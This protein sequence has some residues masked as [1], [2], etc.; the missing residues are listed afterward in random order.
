MPSKLAGFRPNGGIIK[1]TNT[2][3]GFK[4]RY[5]IWNTGTK[6]TIFFLNGRTEYIEKYSETISKF[7]CRNY[8]VVSLDWRSQGLSQRYFGRRDIGHINDFKEYQVDLKAI[9]A[10]KEVKKLPKPFI[11]VSHSMGGLIGLRTLISKNHGFCGAIFSAP[12]WGVKI[13]ENAVLN[14]IKGLAPVIKNPGIAKIKLYPGGKKPY[15]LQTSAKENSLTSDETQFKR[16]QKIMKVEPKLLVGPPTVGWGLAA[17]QELE[18]LSKVKSPDIPILIFMS[19]EETVVD[20]E[21]IKR[22]AEKCVNSK[23]VEINKARHEVF[24]ETPKVQQ[25]VWKHVDDFLLKL[26]VTTTRQE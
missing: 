10:L 16:L 14:L 22:F 6:G 2:S 1:F 25:S 21:A 4:I 8:S 24:L 11:L 17:A 15:V 5:G 26:P 19:A 23:L 3:D 13:F 18:K 7:L 20:N 9:H 12:V